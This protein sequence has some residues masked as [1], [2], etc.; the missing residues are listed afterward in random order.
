MHEKNK[1]RHIPWNRYNL[2]KYRD[3][4]FW[5]YRPALLGMHDIYRTDKVSADMGEIDAIFIAPINTFYLIS[6]SDK[7]RLLVNQS[8]SLIFIWDSST[9]RLQVTAALN[10]S[11]SQF[12]SRSLLLR[13]SWSFSLWQRRTMHCYLQRMF[14]NYSKTRKKGIKF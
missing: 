5:S 10:C 4:H 6:R 13:W 2:E 8:I 12:V 9:F 1:Y 11:D 7:V 14:S 3:I